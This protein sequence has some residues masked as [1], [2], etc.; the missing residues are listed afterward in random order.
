VLVVPME[1][2][3]M[4]EG[5]LPGGE[6]EAHREEPIEGVGQVAEEGDKERTGYEPPMLRPLRG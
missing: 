3:T 6:E 2:Q 5:E 1:E 4:S